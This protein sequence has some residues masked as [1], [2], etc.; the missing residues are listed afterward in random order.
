MYFRYDNERSISV[1]FPF[2]RVMTPY[3]MPDTAS[4]PVNFSIHLTEWEPG[5]E[6]DE[7]AHPD[8]MEAMYCISGS[9]VATVDA[10][11]YPLTANTMIAAAPGERHQIKNTGSEPLRVLCIF[12]PPVTAD[13]LR[14][15]A[16]DAVDEY[17]QRAQGTA[18]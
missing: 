7:H 1:P 17:N 16:Q 18:Q 2:S 6:V 4:C 15:R 8:G 5:A 14:Q 12:S 9:G 13:S 11:E 10:D 3:M